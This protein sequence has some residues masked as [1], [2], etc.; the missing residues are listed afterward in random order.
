MIKRAMLSFAIS[1]LLF[2]LFYVFRETIE[3]N[4]LLL[5][6]YMLLIL[7]YVFGFF[8]VVFLICNFT[9]K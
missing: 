6:P 1:A 9:K 5:R 3:E 7:G 2:V 4:N 8:G